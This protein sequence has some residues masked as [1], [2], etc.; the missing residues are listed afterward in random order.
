MGLNIR[1]TGLDVKILE[2]NLTMRAYT[3]FPLPFVVESNV[4]SR[5]QN[6]GEFHAVILSIILLLQRIKEKLG[7]RIHSIT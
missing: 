1:P 3:L 4:E 7:A 2:G 5:Y 6:F